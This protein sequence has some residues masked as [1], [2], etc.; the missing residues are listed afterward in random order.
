[1]LG[2]ARV[3]LLVGVSGGA[4]FGASTPTPNLRPPDTQACTRRPPAGSQPVASPPLPSQQQ[5]SPPLRHVPPHRQPHH[6]PPQPQQPHHRQQGGG[7]K[8]GGHRGQQQHGRRGSK[9]HAWF[10]V[11]IWVLAL[12]L[13]VA[14]CSF[15]LQLRLRP[16]LLNGRSSV[17]IQI[18]SKR[19]VCH[20]RWYR[21]QP[22]APPEV[23]SDTARARSCGGIHYG[24]R[25]GGWG[26]GRSLGAPSA[27]AAKG[28]ARFGRSAQSGFCPRPRPP[29][30][31]VPVARARRIP[32]AGPPRKPPLRRPGA[33]PVKGP[34]GPPV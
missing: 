32:N 30:A 7:A 17:L 3:C 11:C 10:G 9:V 23:V 26:A 31:A 28:P 21:T 13:A 24:G 22:E 5:R 14:G 18:S 6:Q 29:A 25:L 1:V 27:A 4:R 2:G 34:C 16:G 15:R 19:L 33:P 12:A 8:S 20:L